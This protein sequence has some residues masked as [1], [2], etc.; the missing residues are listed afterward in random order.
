MSNKFP[1]DATGVGLGLHCDNYCL[2]ES[3]T[4]RHLSAAAL[5]STLFL[6]LFSFSL[7]HVLADRAIITSPYQ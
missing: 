2:R 1:G 3:G 4:F 6:K 7:L 5:E